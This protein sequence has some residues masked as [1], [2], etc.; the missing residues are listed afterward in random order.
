[1]KSGNISVWSLA[2][3]LLTAVFVQ[4]QQAA[5]IAR[6]GYLSPGRGRSSYSEALQQGLRDLGYLEGNNIAFEYRNADGKFDQLPNLAADLVR[7]KVDVIVAAGDAPTDAARKASNKIPIVMVLSHD[8]VAVGH[9]ASLAKP[10]GNVTGLSTLSAELAGKRVELLKEIIPKISRLSMLRDPRNRGTEPH[11][12]EIKSAARALGL[13]T[14]SFELRSSDEF[15]NAFRAVAKT[16]ADALIIL[17]GALFNI[18]QHLLI[19]SSAKLRIPT[20]FPEETYV[21]I[22]GLMAY[23]TSYPAQFRR[24]ATYVDKILKG[25][26]PADV[27][28]EQPTKFDLVINLKTAKQ[29]GLTIPPN[30]LARADRVI[31]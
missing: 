2:T 22:G 15:A 1:M 28:V 11:L 5:K 13:Q 30:V 27:P 4:A 18:H 19:N 23:A 3:V 6:I 21:L 29:M 9:V 10:G 26:K 14:Q 31:R 16:H 12:T 20:M 7:L 17:P 8:P 25:A 24:A